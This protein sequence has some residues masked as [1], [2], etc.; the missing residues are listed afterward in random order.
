MR[1]NNNEQKRKTQVLPDFPGF[2]PLNLADHEGHGDDTTLEEWAEMI[3]ANDP[4]ISPLL[5]LQPLFIIM[6]RG[7]GEV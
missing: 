2:T 3:Q 7:I 1:L 6:A 5:G 4:G